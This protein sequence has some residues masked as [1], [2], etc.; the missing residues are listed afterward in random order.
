MNKYEAMIIFPESMKEEMLDGALEKV[1]GEVEKLGGRV[2]NKTRMGRRVFARLL[3]KHAGG[4]YAV[5]GF[6]LDGSKIAPLQARFKLNEDIF[7]VQV[8]R[9]AE[10][11]VEA[12]K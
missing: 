10:A 2:E 9:A 1:A 8:V 7:R 6:F 12:A 5:L 3:K 4:Q 11:P